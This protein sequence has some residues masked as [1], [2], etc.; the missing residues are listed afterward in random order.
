VLGAATTALLLGVAPVGAEPQLPSTS[1]DLSVA[2]EDTWPMAG[3]CPA[4]TRATR[5]RLVTGP[6]ES[7]WTLELPGK[8]EQEPCVWHDRVVVASRDDKAAYLDIVRL[9]DGKPVVPRKKWEGRGVLEPVLWNDYV[10]VRKDSVTFEVLRPVPELSMTS[11]VA[12]LRSTRAPLVVDGDFIVCIGGLL[13]RRRLGAEAPIWVAETEGPKGPL[14]ARDDRLYYVIKRDSPHYVGMEVLLVEH[15][16]DNGQQR[17]REVSLGWDTAN[18]DQHQPWVVAGHDELFVMHPDGI[19]LQSGPPAT[20]SRVV[21]G[22]AVPYQSLCW[23]ACWQERSIVGLVSQESGSVLASSAA[24]IDDAPPGPGWRWWLL[25]SGSRHADFLP[26]ERHDLFV[27][28]GVV[29]TPAGAFDVATQRIVEAYVRPAARDDG[30]ER[31]ELAIPARETLLVARP[32]QVVARRASRTGTATADGPRLVPDAAAKRDFPGASVL[33]PDGGVRTGATTIAGP[34]G[35]VTVGGKPVG[36]LDQVGLVVGKTGEVVHGPDTAIVARGLPRVARDRSRAAWTS[37]A[38]ATLASRDAATVR[39]ALRDLI[40]RG[41]KVDDVLAL[42]RELTRIE[43][44]SAVAARPDPAKIADAERRRAALVA[45]DADVAWTAFRTLPDAMPL[46]SR[47][48]VLRAALATDP[49]LP[50][51]VEWLRARLPAG[52]VPADTVDTQDWVDVIEAA[53]HTTLS[54][55]APTE[56]KP[57]SPD[58]TWLAAGRAKW[59]PD[60]VALR[61]ERLLLL[62]PVVAPGRI[63]HALALGELVCSTLDG[64]FDLTPDALRSADPLV[65][66]LYETKEEYLRMSAGR[67]GHADAAWL[68]TTLGHYSPADGLS[69][70]YVPS[71]D[72]DFESTLSTLAHELTHHWVDRRLPLPAGAQRGY[73]VD[74]PGYFL[75][76]GFAVLVE[77][78]VY[79]LRRRQVTTLD[80]RANSLDIVATASPGIQWRALLDMTQAEFRRIPETPTQE[81]PL[82]WTLGKRRK[83]TPTNLFYAQAGA[84]CHYLWDADGG[85]HREKLK[86]WVRDLHTAKTKRDDAERRVGRAAL[87][88]GELVREWAKSVSGG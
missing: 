11:V 30:R 20:A 49:L 19:P 88:F 72:A 47:L 78:F 60:V 56:G 46:A 59:R 68:A 80:P 42:Q 27:A 64:M 9:S 44:P 40:E 81:V 66:L 3:A 12:T 28:R 8:I 70:L 16:L 17:G 1:S 7:V 29:R 57:A 55:V 65:V 21:L 22:T 69:R 83:L 79:D 37:H 77:E 2:A 61:S 14:T 50:A 85:A 53:S 87:S 41:G 33:A 4:R 25:A 84:V 75:E 5:T 38:R 15:A 13:E 48:D 58:Q 63:A 86:A 6:T 54:V 31:R 45:A 76:E 10:I 36:T 82:R 52:L 73:G 26:T 23:P 32:R 51:A 35:T 39:G 67:G 24:R 34:Q 18:A 43:N 71:G 62:T 74:T